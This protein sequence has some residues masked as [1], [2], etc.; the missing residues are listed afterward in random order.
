MNV[1][2]EQLAAHLQ[3]GLQPVYVISGDEHLLVQEACQQIRESARAKGFAEREIF[4]V[5]PHFNWD[6][7]IASG[8]SLSL[9][10]Q[11]KLI[12]LRLVFGKPGDAGSKALLRY[13]ASPSDQNILLIITPKLDK[14]TQKSKWFKALEQA[15]VFIAIWPVGPEQLPQWIHQR[16]KAAGLQADTEAIKLLAALVDGNLLAAAQ[17]IEKLQLLVD[18]TELTAETI[19]QAVSDSSHFNVFNLV[20][21]AITGNTK[22][23]LSILSRLKGEGVDPLPIAWALT[24]EIRQLSQIAHNIDSG[25]SAQQAMQKY[26]VWKNRQRMV[27]SAL[28]RLTSNT[29]DELIRLSADIDQTVKGMLPDD[30]W[31]K[32]ESVIMLL[33]GKPTSLQML[34]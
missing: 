34:D 4:T 8:N 21:M 7:F 26:G 1:K 16:M 9:F 12:E 2:I 20:D 19:R 25:M 22:K 18:G 6:D 10:S 23:S 15:G 14:N 11:Q 24:R 3:N 30:P 32:L 27:S 29:L 17:E 28:A 5:E 31:D 13:L 33:T